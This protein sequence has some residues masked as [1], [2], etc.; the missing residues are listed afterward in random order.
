MD[1]RFSVTLDDIDLGQALDGLKIRAESWQKTADYLET[2]FT[3]D[4]FFIPEECTDAHEASRIAEHY[5]RIIK[6][7]ETQV[8]QQGGW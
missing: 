4:E 7:I 8:S 1:K 5:E 6:K 3:S 2:G